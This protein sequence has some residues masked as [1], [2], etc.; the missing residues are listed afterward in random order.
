[1]FAIAFDLVVAAAEEHH[2]R[3]VTA[4]Y[5]DIATTLRKFKFESIQ[6]SVYVTEKDDMANLFAALLALKALPGSPPWC[7]TFAVS[8]SRAG[9]T[10][11]PSS[12]TNRWKDSPARLYLWNS[13]N[14]CIMA[15][16]ARLDP[17]PGGS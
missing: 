7:G 2:P 17:A 9:A 8:R 5:A 15:W 13:P 16:P 4:A 3:G 1:M 11:R 14:A 10:S 12:R 6:G